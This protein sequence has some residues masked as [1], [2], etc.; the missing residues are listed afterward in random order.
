MA[1]KG[2][3]SLFI[4]HYSKLTERKTHL[5]KILGESKASAE[6]ITEKNFKFFPSAKIEQTKILGVSK[7]LLGMDDVQ[8]FIRSSLPFCN[9]LQCTRTQ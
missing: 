5:V 8:F 3:F 4:V 2:D 9:L 1:A 6:W 7:K